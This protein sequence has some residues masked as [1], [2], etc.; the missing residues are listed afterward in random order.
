M[1]FTLA[2]VDWLDPRACLLRA[3]LDTEMSE[4]YAGSFTDYPPA[5]KSLLIAAFA[6]DPSTVV[7]TVLV[8]EARSGIPVGHAGLRPYGVGGA[9]EV[10]KVVVD[11]NYRGRGI[12]RTLMVEL[13]HVARE[14]DAP[15]LVLQT[16]DRQPAAIGLY[17][18][19]GYRLIPPYAPFELMSNALCYEKVLALA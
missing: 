4:I 5:V 2:R 17:E 19:V 3:S 9:L 18:S 7:A 11:A 6:V 10:K 14:L 1:G 15:S 13:E 16:G 8:I 12:S